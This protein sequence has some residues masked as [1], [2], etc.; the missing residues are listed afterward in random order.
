MKTTTRAG[1]DRFHAFVSAL[2]ISGV[3]AIEASKCRTSRLHTSFHLAA[4]SLIMKSPAAVGLVLAEMEKLR[5]TRPWFN[6]SL[7][8]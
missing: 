6:I 5:L 7:T 1:V 3:L 4:N 2:D 8:W